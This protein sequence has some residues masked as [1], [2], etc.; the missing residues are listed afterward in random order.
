MSVACSAEP[1]IHLNLQVMKNLRL[2]KM[3]RERERKKSKFPK[4][5]ENFILRYIFLPLRFVL[6]SKFFF[7]LYWI[8]ILLLLV[9]FKLF[10]SSSSVLIRF[11]STNVGRHCVAWKLDHFLSTVAVEGR[12]YYWLFA[13]CFF[14]HHRISCDCSFC[15]DAAN[16][17]VAAISK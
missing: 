3:K 15:S 7:F 4:K 5:S 11:G 17:I 8:F 6:P 9:I 16:L 10:S 12:Q 14:M 2:Q 1:F 13:F